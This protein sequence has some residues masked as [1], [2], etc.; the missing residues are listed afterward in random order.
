M[1]IEQ[2]L[3]RKRAAIG[4]TATEEKIYFCLA[5]VDPSLCLRSAFAPIDGASTEEER[6]HNGPTTEEG[7]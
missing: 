2:Y 7:V 4:L 3:R 6:T 5:S 1:N